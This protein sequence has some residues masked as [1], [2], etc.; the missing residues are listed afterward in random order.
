MIT[1]LQKGSFFF[2]QWEQNSRLLQ[3]YLNHRPMGYENII[4]NLRLMYIIPKGLVSG[5]LL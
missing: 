4:E 5:G 1:A 3:E 2:H